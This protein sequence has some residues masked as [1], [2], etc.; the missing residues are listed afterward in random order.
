MPIRSLSRFLLSGA[1]LIPVTAWCQIRWS[2]D[3]SQLVFSKKG[4][5]RTQICA[6]NKDGSQFTRLTSDDTDNFEPSFSPNGQ[7]IIFISQATGNAPRQVYTMNKDGSNPIN[8]TK[9]LVNEF[10]PRWSPKGDKIAIHSDRDGTAQIYLMDTDGTNPMR[11]TDLAFNNSFPMWSPDGSQ[12]ICKTVRVPNFVL[13][14]IDLKTKALQPLDLQPGFACTVDGFSSGGDHFLYHCFDAR[15][16]YTVEN[17]TSIYL[18][19]LHKN[20]STII[21]T[22]IERC[23]DVRLANDSTVIYISDYNLYSLNM[24]TGKVKKIHKDVMSAEVSPDK[25][26]IAVFNVEESDV[27]RFRMNVEGYKFGIMRLDGSDYHQYD[28]SIIKNK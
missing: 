26:S 28:L 24:A 25:Q 15:D 16:A 7:K 8:L 23:R 3:G 4:H 10:D 11:M 5:D 27:G 14:L 18:Y 2:P 12:I 21:K 22:R 19:D 1:V 17:T 13:T 6:I 20:E 9:S